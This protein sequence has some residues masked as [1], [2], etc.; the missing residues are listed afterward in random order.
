MGCYYRMHYPL[1]TLLAC[2]T[3][4]KGVLMMGA[5]KV[6]QGNRVSLEPWKSVEICVTSEISV[7]KGS[8]FQTFPHLTEAFCDTITTPFQCP[9][10]FHPK[11]WRISIIM[12]TQ[13]LES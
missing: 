11:A 9:A 8:C 12:E 6:G 7:L 2:G 13:Y 10:T 5:S 4:G 3:L 1:P